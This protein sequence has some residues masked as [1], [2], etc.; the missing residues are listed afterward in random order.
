MAWLL[1][2]LMLLLLL[3]LS[4]FLR[5]FLQL[6]MP[7]S[8]YNSERPFPRFHEETFAAVAASDK[9]EEMVMSLTQGQGMEDVDEILMSESDMDVLDMDEEEFDEKLNNEDDA[10][11]SEDALTLSTK[12]FGSLNS[13]DE[14]TS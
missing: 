9:F 8:I 2:L 6:L 13:S 1:M 5:P 3:F 11:P 10:L 4:S 12:L 7:L 14:T